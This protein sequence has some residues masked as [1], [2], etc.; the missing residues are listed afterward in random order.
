MRNKIEKSL[1]ILVFRCT[2]W[3]WEQIV[4]PSKWTIRVSVSLRIVTKNIPLKSLE[5]SGVFPHDY[6]RTSQQTSNC[7]STT[8]WWC[9]SVNHRDHH[10]ST[11]LQNWKNREKRAKRAK[12]A[13][14]GNYKASEASLENCFKSCKIGRRGIVAKMMHHLHHHLQFGGALC[15]LV[16]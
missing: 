1:I 3:F 15:Y 5:S 4:F 9:S 6:Y 13:K 11:Q 7:S 16:K 12:R 8:L 2:W 10:F 14:R